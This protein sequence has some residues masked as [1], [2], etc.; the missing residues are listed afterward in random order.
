MQQ[1]QY[2]SIISASPTAVWEVLWSDKTFR[3]WATHIDEGM[4][5]QGEVA[6]GQ[7]VTF[8]GAG[9]NAE[10]KSLVEVCT[11]YSRVTFRHKS[12]APSSDGQGNEWAGGAE[13][14]ILEPSGASTKLTIE[15]DVPSEHQEAFAIRIPKALA[16]IKALA[17]KSNKYPRDRKYVAAGIT[18]GLCWGVVLGLAVFDNIGVGVG[19]GLALGVAIGIML[20]TAKK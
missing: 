20:D 8:V 16:A 19:I 11:P 17:E 14:Y 1:M 18:I 4:Y 3:Q 12:D 13:S 15:L 10:V 6:Q 2:T 5:L 7:V 9:G